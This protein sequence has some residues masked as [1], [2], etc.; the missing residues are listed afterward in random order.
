M[1]AA[2]PPG[3]PILVPLELPRPLAGPGD[4][5]RL[6]RADDGIDLAT[7]GGLAALLDPT[8]G[9]RS[10]WHGPVQVAGPMRLQ[11]GRRLLHPAP[12]LRLGQGGWERRIPLPGGHGAGVL[13]ER[14]VL[15]DAAPALLIQW[16]LE[17]EG[18]GSGPPGRPPR[19]PR[20]ELQPPA[21]RVPVSVEPGGGSGSWGVAV[22]LPGARIEELRRRFTPPHARERTRHRR[23]GSGL[24][25]VE[26]RLRA[27]PP[28]LAKALPYLASAPLGVDPRGHPLAPFV[29]GVQDARPRF[30]RAGQLAEVGI[31]GLQAGWPGVGWAALDALLAGSDPPPLPTLHLASELAR[32]TGDLERL[33]RLRAP[34]EGPLDALETAAAEAAWEPPAAFPGPARVLSR[35][36]EGVQRLGNGWAHE[37]ETIRNRLLASGGGR[38]SEASGPLRRL[39]VLGASDPA[40][41]TPDL[42]LQATLPPPHAFAPMSAPGVRHHRT[43]HAARLVRS[44]VEGFLGADPDASYGRL[45]LAPDLTAIPSEIGVRGLRVGG[46]QVALDCRQ[47]RGS[48]SIR[49]FQEGGRVP[50]NVVFRPT[51]PLAPP[52][53]V[54][55]GG[56]E[57]EVSATP[58]EDGVRLS[59]QF[60][61]DP[62]RRV[63]IERTS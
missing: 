1:T 10:L 8:R 7:G 53:R 6:L 60:P 32:W 44:W 63:V 36:A 14:G 42:D 34:L 27:F 30:A 49:V 45:T 38:A 17:G 33:A 29:L 3:D 52:V 13:L 24:A 40:P 4:D 11:W 21:G 20:V 56:K 22:L 59:L 35:L 9:L 28:G 25:P 54:T 51:V 18:D 31:G 39:P 2:S 62:E 19:A 12:G 46:S 15:V 5:V 26:G 58:V 16:T 41:D 37:L 47:G 43:L 50:L 55:I 23:L 61:L 57:A 48:C